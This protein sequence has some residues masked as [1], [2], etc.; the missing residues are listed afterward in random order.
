MH[1]HT[2]RELHVSRDLKLKTQIYHP[3]K[4][5]FFYIILM[6]LYLRAPR[7][8]ANFPGLFRNPGHS[9]VMFCVQFFHF[10]TPISTFSQQMKVV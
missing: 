7:E 9:S 6:E 4:N 10:F 2:E 1:L 5:D 3:C 8:L